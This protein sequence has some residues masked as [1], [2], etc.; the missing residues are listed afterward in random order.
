MAVRTRLLAVSTAAAV[1]L[2]ATAAASSAV[3]ATS[4]TPG[5][6][7]I[8]AG[9]YHAV[10]PGPANAT[11]VAAHS[12]AVDGSGNLYIADPLSDVV[13]K[14]TPGGTLSIIAGTGHFGRP[15]AGPATSSNLNHPDAVAV[16]SSGNVYI[17]DTNNDLVE[18]VTPGGTLTIFAGNGLIGTPTPGP[19]T[20][21]DLSSP[22]DVAVDT[23]GN[24]YIADTNNS[25]VEKVTPGGTLSVIAGTGTSGAPTPGPATSSKLFKPL[26]IAVDSSGNVY[27]ADTDNNEVEEVTSGGT[28]SIIAG[29]GASGAPTPG[30]ATSSKLFDPSGVAV[31]SSGNV[32]IADRG[33]QR[34]EQVTSG[35][36]LSVIAGTGAVG[37]PTAGTATS[38][39]L[40]DPSGVAVDSSGNVY[41]ADET[42]GVV[43][44]VSS[45]TMSIVAGL[46]DFGP[47][48]AGAATSSELAAPGGVAVDSSGNFYIADTDN[49]VVV[50]VTA[51]GTLSVIAGTGTSG[52]PT[53][54]P[55]TSSN[56]AS[57][58]GVAVDS[59]GN[60]YIADTNNNE[61][62]KVTPGGTLSVIAGTGATGA[63]TPG[64]ATSSKLDKPAAVAVDGSGNVYIADNDNNEI[65]KVTPGGTLSIIAGTGTESTPTPGPAT[66]SDLDNPL[67]IA[68]DSSGNVY[69]AD[70]DNNV[71][72][73]VTPGGTLSIIAGTGTNG[74]LDPRPGDEQRTVRPERSGG[75]QQRQ[76]LHR[77]HQQQRRS[78]R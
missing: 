45:G 54:G 68:V 14:V 47:P 18:K 75:R 55:A 58:S 22:G 43:G 39:K 76:P 64:P 19:A 26:G 66:S 48:T 72:E 77:R 24:V 62:E 33:N 38:S 51:G 56:L 30:P 29:T 31:D 28:L 53:P 23:S 46:V 63:P 10:S 40:F 67:G 36:T 57:P 27:I 17:A 61:I 6:L 4:G 50:K 21:S 5:S 25:E 9:L 12:V 59:S 60:L 74:T 11:P 1:C 44:K 65:E 7:A 15:T 32:Y 71:V 2:W 49:N 42:A 73:K 35:G 34:T 70:T 3:A 41:V 16:D 8:V 69:I 20:S 37:A 78:R 52:A 13:E